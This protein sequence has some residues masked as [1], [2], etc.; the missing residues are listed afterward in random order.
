M[1]RKDREVTDF[2]EIVEILARCD[3]IRLGIQAEGCPYVVPVSFGYAVE[4]GKLALY[5]HGADV[6][7]KHTLLAQCD[8]VCV[9]ADRFLG[10]VDTG[11]SYTANYESVIGCGTAAV[12]TGAQAVRGLALLLRHCGFGT[13]SAEACEK[14]T[15]VYR[16]ETDRITG[17]RRLA[18]QKKSGGT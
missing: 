5:F 17:K 13:D 12:V 18:E 11:H 9:E 6:G 10:Y 8:R 14:R 16:I 1:R 4:D 15:R 2:D 7:R 3:V